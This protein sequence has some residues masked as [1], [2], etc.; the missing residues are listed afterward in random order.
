MSNNN[1][2]SVGAKSPIIPSIYVTKLTPKKRKKKMN[3]FKRK[4]A[5]WGK[6]VWNEEKADFP[7]EAVQQSNPDLTSKKTF[8]F[9]IYTADG[10]YIIENNMTQYY[11]E[12][13]NPRLTVVKSYDDIPDVIKKIMMIE[14]ISS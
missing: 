10:G 7:Y 3:W 8:H 1:T 12:S 13:D 6:E 5:E 2:Y 4:F 14:N 11:R 9:K